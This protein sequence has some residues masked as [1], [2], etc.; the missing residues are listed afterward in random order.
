MPGRHQGFPKGEACLP[1]GVFSLIRLIENG[2]GPENGI[3]RPGKVPA[4]KTE[5]TARGRSRPGKW[6]LPH[7]KVPGPGEKISRGR[8]APARI[9][10]S[11]AAGF[12]GINLVHAEQTAGKEEKS[13]GRS[14]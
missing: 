7:E 5:F 13:E 9:R 1:P 2:P 12:P 8:K 6:N 11:P 10:D 4:W 3:C 14:A